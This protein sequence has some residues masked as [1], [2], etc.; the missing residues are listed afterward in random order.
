MALAAPA[1]AG[2]ARW[3]APFRLA[4]PYDA[5]LAPAQLAVSSSGALAAGFSVFDEDSPQVS[6][7]MIAV[8]GERGATRVRRVSGTQE[9]LGLAYDGAR[10]ALLGGVSAPGQACC[11]RAQ[12]TELAGAGFTPGHLVGDG[13]TGATTGTLQPL[14]GGGLLAALATDRGVW[15]AQS[16]SGTRF[17]STR[18]LSSGSAVPW[19]LAAAQGTGGQTSVAW[20]AAPDGSGQSGPGQILVAGGSPP[21]APGRAQAVLTVRPGRE[22]DELALAPLGTGTTAAWIE[23]W[24]DAHGAYRSQAVVADLR[25]P[26]RARALPVAGQVAS[27]LTLAGGAG[28]E[29]LLA[30]R[31]CDSRGACSARAALRPRGQHFGAPVRLGPIDPG[32]APA[33]AITPGGAVVVAWVAGGQVFAEWRAPGA[34]GFTAPHRLSPTLYAAD[35]V[36]A[37]GPGSEAVAAWTQGTVAPSVVAAVLR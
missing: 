13:L 2:A 30:F 32:Q 24:F 29:Q 5:D 7:A 25:Q 8:R 15:A 21:A 28:G 20:L 17:G 4:G 11:A 31:A 3:G 12:V 16:S 27:G 36:L 23:S 35:L 1:R 33:A 37:A 6:Q 9:I 34:P 22:L 10:P 19:V 18:R 26:L 14:P